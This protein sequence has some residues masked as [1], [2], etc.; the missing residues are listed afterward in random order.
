MNIQRIEKISST[1]TALKT[2]AV[3]LPSMTMLI[4]HEQTAGRGQRGNHWE[5]APGLNLT[6]S[7]FLEPVPIPPVRQ[8][9]ISEAFAL[10]FVDTLASYGIDATIKWPNDIYVGDRKISGILI[11][12]S[13]T[14]SSID[15]SLMSAGLNINQTRFISDAPNPTSML[16]EKGNAPFDIPQVTALLADN[17]ERRL[18]RHIYGKETPHDEFMRHLYRNDGAFY[19][20]HDNIQDEEITA[21]IA[22][23]APDGLLTLTLSDGSQRQYRF[24]E[25]SF[26]L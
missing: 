1:H 14:G 9:I 20:F 16:L 6:F 17:I 3:T 10:A 7:F 18:Q 5:A 24:K 26:T 19:L 22:G 13:L 21:A 12:H 2:G 8:F 25:V 11:D 4:A 23:V 15:R